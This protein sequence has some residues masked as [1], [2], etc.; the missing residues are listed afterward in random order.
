MPTISIIVPIYNVD[1]YLSKCIES[2]LVQTYTDFELILINDGSEDNCRRICEEYAGIDKRIKVIH[3]ENG[4][5]SSAR[6][7]GIKIATGEFLAFVDPD[8]TIEPNMYEVLIHTADE[9]KADVVVCPY[10]TINLIKGSSSISRVWKNVH[11]SLNKRDI[12]ND[13][14]PLIIID[15][16]YSLVSSVNKLYRKQIFDTF[17]IFFNE[18]INFGEDERL[19]IKLLTLIN[20]LVFIKEPLYNYFIHKRDSLTQEFKN[21]FYEEYILEI[22]KFK[23][24]VCERYYMNNYINK[25]K[26]YYIGVTLQYMDDIV[27]RNIPNEHKLILMSSILNNRDFREDIFN[28]KFTSA[29]GK[30]L[31]I[32]CLLKNEKLLLNLII[33]KKRLQQSISR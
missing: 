18:S 9:Y 8:D 30:L 7:R 22:K 6:N 23:I 4:G 28:Y 16:T 12:E 20:N 25:V 1:K 5:V 14:L 2:I 24:E 10:K 13:L 3:K 33:M 19:N 21:N 32:I 26:N 17:D 29:Y 15:K 27:G 31:K 11:C